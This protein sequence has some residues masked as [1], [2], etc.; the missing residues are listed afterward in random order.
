MKRTSKVLLGAAL[1]TGLAAGF[2]EGEARACGGCFAPTENPTVVTDHKMIFSIS[3][4]QSTLY[5]QITYQG[6]PASFAWVLPIVG[7]VDVGL[8]ADVV[9][10]T[11]NQLTTT[12][13]VAPPQSCARSGSSSSGGGFGATNAGA[14]ADAPPVTVLKKEVVGPYE[15][16]QLQ[17]TSPDALNTWLSTNGFSIPADVLPV[18]ATYQ[19]ESFNFLAM[20][21]VPGKGIQDM[22]PVRVTTKGASV[23]L[24]L[25]MVAAGTGPTVGITLWV[26]GEGRY[27]PQNFATFSIK[28]DDIV[29]DWATSKSNYTELRAAETA[30]GNGSAWEVESSMIVYRQ[31]VES[32]VQNG[33]YDGTTPY[34]AT[35]EARAALD[36]LPVKDDQGNVTKTALQVRNEDMSTLF[37]GIP[38]STSRVT[39]VRADLSRA[40]LSQDLLLKA[41]SDQAVVS[42]VRQL[43]KSVGDPCGPGSTSGS[44]TTPPSSSSGAGGETFTCG[45]SSTSR[46]N[47]GVTLG[48]GLGAVAIASALRRRRR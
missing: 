15:T 14:S 44:A 6:S 5:D 25:R 29:W 34:P 46:P 28:T 26:V 43:T 27:E 12:Q 4:E 38:T 9:F 39:R 1:V 8:S 37:Y 3:K 13:I 18:I 48:L 35:D 40:A 30:K 32:S 24:P 21:L 20:K 33:S 47:L 7:T 22:R 36:Y 41:S 16:V 45:V 23:A 10:S 42:N 19:K 17:A 2:L 11:L 31:N